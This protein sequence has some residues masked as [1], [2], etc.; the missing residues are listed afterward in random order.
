MYI[1][2]IGQQQHTG[3]YVICIYVHEYIYIYIYI[4]ILYRTAAAM[5]K[6]RCVANVLLMCG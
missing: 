2:Y 5:E 1:V 6:K 3:M 4:Y